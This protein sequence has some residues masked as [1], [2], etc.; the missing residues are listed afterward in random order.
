MAGFS[1]RGKN[2]GDFGEIYYIPDESERGAYAL[3]YKVEEEEINGHDG[4]Y[5]AGYH[6]QPREWNLRCYYDG[7]TAKAREEI[8]RWFGRGTWGQLI[9]DDRDY[10]YYDVRPNGRITMQDHLVNTCR[11]Q[12]YEG[13]MTIPMKA[14]CPYGKLTAASRIDMSASVGY[15]VVGTAI[16]GEDNLPITDETLVLPHSMMPANVFTSGDATYL[17]YNPGTE[18]TPLN[19]KI[20]GS[21]TNGLI[22]NLSNGQNCAIKNMTAAAT[23]DVGKYVE[24]DAETGRVTLSGVINFEMHDYGYI[25]LQPCLP[26]AKD[27]TITYATGSTTIASPGIFTYDMVGQY[28]YLHGTWHKIASLT[29]IYNMTLTAAMDATGAEITNIVP[30]NELRFTGFTLSGLEWSYIP[31]VR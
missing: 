23:T 14:Y 25:W 17:I 16:V 15:A 20:A 21:C 26:F 31:R 24:I 8:L 22:T 28:V 27:V 19:I 29:S 6:V 30:M 2:I 4:A 3:P 9:F 7:I 18:L 13:I 10:V 5:Y 1:Y 11:G 12:L